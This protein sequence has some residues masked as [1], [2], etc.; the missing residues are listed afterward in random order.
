MRGRK[1]RGLSRERLIWR[2]GEANRP[3]ALLHFIVGYFLAEKPDLLGP[4]P[5]LF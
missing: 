5:F 2:L 1:L 3:D 4:V